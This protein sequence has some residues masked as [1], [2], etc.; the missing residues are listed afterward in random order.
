[1]KT[2]E[3]RILGIARDSDESAGFI[4]YMHAV[5]DAAAE[6]GMAFFVE[7]GDGN[8]FELDDIE[9]EDLSGWLVPLEKAEEFQELCWAGDFKACNAFEG[10]VSCFAEWEIEESGLSIEFKTYPLAI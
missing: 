9:G 3:S 6:Q 7:A 1:M 5:Q 10:A 2:Q 4:K 8:E